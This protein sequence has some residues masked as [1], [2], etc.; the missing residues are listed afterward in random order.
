MKHSAHKPTDPCNCLCRE[1]VYAS[2]KRMSLIVALRP[3]T[4][5]EWMKHNP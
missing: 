2:L 1:C 3:I 5:K 4:K